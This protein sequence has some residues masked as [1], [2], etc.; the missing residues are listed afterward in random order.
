M[1]QTSKPRK[2]LTNNT[3]NQNFT[4]MLINYAKCKKAKNQKIN[5]TRQKD[6]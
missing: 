2:P 3:N 1:L 4:Q 6:K 5:T